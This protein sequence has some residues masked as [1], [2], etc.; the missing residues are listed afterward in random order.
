MKS[1]SSI[2]YFILFFSFTLSAQDKILEKV[3]VSFLI[4]Y[5]V[6]GQ[7]EN[8]NFVTKNGLNF[9]TNAL[10]RLN[11]YISTGIG[12]G[13]ARLQNETFVPLFVAV[14]AHLKDAENSAY[15]KTN[16]G[17]SIATNYVLD[18]L[19]YYELQGETYFSIAYGYQ[20]RIT[21]KV[22]LNIEL[23]LEFQEAELEYESFSGT[24]F[25]DEMQNY[26]LSFKTGVKF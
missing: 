26:F 21:E 25:E 4:G 1:R 2:L 5:Q 15:F 23:N 24:S 6:G 11:N 22:D 20:W 10:Y 7:G 14:K 17:H 3:D 8:R 16:I 19:E 18:K 9:Q 13:Y 12:L